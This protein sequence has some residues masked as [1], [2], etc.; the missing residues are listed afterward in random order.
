MSSLVESTTAR[1]I[2]VS[3]AAGPGGFSRNR[4]W[5]IA[6]LFLTIAF[7]WGNRPLVTGREAPIWDAESFFA[8]A[9]TLVADHAR[10][11]RIVLWNPWESG[12]SPDYAEPELGSQSPVAILT[13]ML[14]GG[15]E[16]GFRGY[17]LLI[18]L[19]GGLG[20]LGLARQLGASAWIGFVVALGFLFCGFYTSHAE[21]T[22]SVYSL[23]FLPWLVW[24]F[25]RAVLERR[26]LPAIQAGALWGLSALGGYPQLTILSSAFVCLW[27]LGRAYI[28]SESDLAC[29][30]SKGYSINAPGK[31][32]SQLV[33]LAAFFIVGAAVLAPS[34]VSFFLEGGT[35]YS[36]RVGP[37]TRQES[38]SSNLIEP[39]A[40]STFSSPYL[41]DLK[42]FNHTLWPH[43]DISLTNVYLGGLVT[44]FAILAVVSQPRSRWRWWLFTIAIFFLACAVGSYLP[45]R[46]WLYDYCVP[47]RYFR[48]PALF[49]AYTIFCASVLAIVGMMDLDRARQDRTRTI[50]IKFVVVSGAIGVFA[51]LA[52]FHVIREVTNV[53]PWLHRANRLLV[54]AWLGSLVVALVFAFVP[55]SRKILPVLLVI[56]AVADARQTI[57]LARMTVSSDYH[58][59][60]TWNRINAAHDP[61]LDLMRN[62]L[63]R[64]LLPPAWIGG[65]KNN[66]N[67]PMKLVTFKN[68]ATMTNTFQ[69]DFPNHPALMGMMTGSDRIYFSSSVVTAMP[70]DTLYAAFLK[71]TEAANGPVV[72]VHSPSQMKQL[73]ERA[74]VHPESAQAAQMVGQLPLAEG[75]PFQ[76]V[77]YTPNHFDINVSA[78]REGWV[79][80]TDRWCRG[81]TATVNGQNIP[82][83]GGDFIFRAVHVHAGEN[84]ITFNY[85]PAGWPTLL[86]LSWG[87]L[88]MV[89]IAPKAAPK[90]QQLFANG[91]RPREEKQIS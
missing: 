73:R 33:A 68:Y 3:D 59:R 41:T 82:V 15:T 10:A 62:G 24:H 1:S 44:I 80:I 30:T 27:A 47:T 32:R 66:E 76:L 75:V 64:D 38:V 42:F 43:S 63:K 12:G 90:L 70:D 53:G 29:S 16:G 51:C 55:M 40:L 54:W 14:L 23:S 34:Y 71:R 88:A 87:T 83:F 7:L 46:G 25:D 61:S 2:D 31:T 17:F 52:Y 67:V 58:S 5:G 49:R 69:M 20:I 65:A 28:A 13:G 8:P 78:P 74:Q 37:R 9:F 45:L 19:F 91:T 77:R 18:W 85:R 26:L 56:L 4:S 81:W 57:R 50:W 22:S 48:N 72:I 86:W 11:G 39:D 35:G 79:L 89:L 36:D 21:H 84:K 6:A 60:R